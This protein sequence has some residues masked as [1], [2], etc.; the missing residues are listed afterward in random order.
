MKHKWFKF[1]FLIILVLILNSCAT[2][3]KG[4]E[5]R[6]LLKNAPD[7]LAVYDLDGVKIPIFTKSVNAPVKSQ[8]GDLIV[9]TDRFYLEYYIDLRSNQTHTL[10]LNYE[11]QES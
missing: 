9:Q 6:V 5:D 3:L 2:I 8:K 11:G 1:T 4:Y 7:N 10:L